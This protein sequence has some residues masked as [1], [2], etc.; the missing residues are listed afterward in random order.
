MGCNGFLD[1]IDSSWKVQPHCSLRSA[2]FEFCTENSNND[3]NNDDPFATSREL[4]FK[5]PPGP[6]PSFWPQ[7]N[8]G[9]EDM[10]DWMLLHV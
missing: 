1:T 3:N 6:Q 8:S 9:N 10:V 5:K 7:I 2:V 4:G